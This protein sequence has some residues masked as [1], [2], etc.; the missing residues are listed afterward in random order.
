MRNRNRTSV[1]KRIF[2][3]ALGSI[4]GGRE[5]GREGIMTRKAATFRF[6]L[7]PWISRWE[8]SHPPRSSSASS[9]ATD[10]Q[11]RAGIAIGWLERSWSLVDVQW[12]WSYLPDT[13]WSLASPYTRTTLGRKNYCSLKEFFS[14][15]EFR[16]MRNTAV[17]LVHFY[18]RQRY[19]KTFSTSPAWTGESPRSLRCFCFYYK[20]FRASSLGFGRATDHR[21]TS[22]VPRLFSTFQL[23]SRKLCS[24][25]TWQK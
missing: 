14:L 12:R 23:H 2:F 15:S 22:S 10:W 16:A 25:C 4:A 5:G 21:S 19:Q 9:S 18:Q 8:F 24:W 6:A 17:I 7:L 11:A 3:G 13:V 1:Q 20:V